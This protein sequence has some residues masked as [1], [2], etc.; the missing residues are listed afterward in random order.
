[1]HVYLIFSHYFFL[2]NSEVIFGNAFLFFYFFDIYVSSFT[3]LFIIFYFTLL[4]L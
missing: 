4:F 3:D 1:M 2:Y